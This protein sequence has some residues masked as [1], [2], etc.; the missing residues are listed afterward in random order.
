MGRRIFL[1]VVTNIVIVLTIS[2][3]LHVAGV[4]SYIDRDGQIRMLAL[5]SFCFVW[6][7]GGAFLSLQ[8]SRWLAK[9]ALGVRLVD[10]N[11]GRE[12]LDAVHATVRRLAEQASLPMPEVGYYESDEVNAFATGPSKRRSLVAVSTGLLQNLSARE[13]EAVLGHELSHI[14]NGDMVT[15]T[16]LQGVIN[17]FVMVIARLVGWGVRA[18]DEDYGRIASLVVTILMEIVLSILG[19]MVVAWF[20][21][22]REFSADAGGAHLAGREAMVAALER[23]RAMQDKVDSKK[24]PSLANFKISGGKSWLRVF[25]THPPLEQRIAALQGRD[26]AEVR[27]AG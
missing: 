25:A 14:A 12:D 3:I 21:R 11:T 18:A 16:L 15:M 2:L 26:A 17:V 22:R 8:L 27:Q 4:G 1:F 24:A 5:V 6:G 20:S 23:L 19:A 9:V 7:M 13:V 10:G